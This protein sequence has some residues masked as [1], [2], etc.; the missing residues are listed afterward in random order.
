MAGRLDAA[1]PGFEAIRHEMVARIMR[2]GAPKSGN[3]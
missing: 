3:R 1:S 2:G